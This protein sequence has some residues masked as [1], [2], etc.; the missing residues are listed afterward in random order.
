MVEGVK[1]ACNTNIDTPMVSG[2]TQLQIHKRINK[3]K[4]T[5]IKFG[6]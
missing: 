4:D 3:I 5:P 6:V 2:V 1:M